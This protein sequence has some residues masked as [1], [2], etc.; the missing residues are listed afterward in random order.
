[1]IDALRGVFDRARKTVWARRADVIGAAIPV[2]AVVLAF[3][4]VLFGGR[5][6]STAS[7]S[8]GTNGFAPFPGQRTVD[9]PRLYQL[10]TGASAWAF[11][12]WAVV[13]NR[14]IRDGEIPLW[15]PYQGAGAPLAANM[16]SAPFDPLFALVDL[17]P[18]T[19]TWDA[20]FILSFA[21]AAVAT[22][23]LARLVRM[24]YVA[25]VTASVTYSL[26]GYFF[27]YSNNHF[28]VVYVY[29]PILCLCAEWVVRSGRLLATFA[30]AA[31]VAACF[32]VGMPEAQ[33]F[34]LGAACA[35]G[36]WRAFVGGDPDRSGRRALLVLGGFACGAAMAA[37]LLLPFREY[38]Q[39][40]YNVHNSTD[41]VG[42][43][44]SPWQYALGWVFPYLN[45]YPIRSTTTQ[46]LSGTVN[47]I[48]GGAMF[49]VL[50]GVASRRRAARFLVPFFAVVIVVLLAKVYG[51]PLLRW[52]G[53]LPVLN[54][55]NFPRYCLPVVGFG[56]AMLAGLGVDAIRHRRING[57]VLAALA[58]LV[59]AL[60]IGALIR[61][62][63]V[64]RQ[65]PLSQTFHQVGV[66]VGAA[67]VIA[68]AI[69]L[70]R[71]RQAAFVAAGVVIIE[72]LVL[73]P[74]ANGYA[75]RAEP[76]TP[77]AWTLTLRDHLRT[78]PTDRVYGLDALLFP[79]DAGAL[80]MYDIRVLDA[81]YVSRYWRYIHTFIE[82][83]ASSRFV[84]GPYGITEETTPANYENNSMF[85]LLGVRYLVARS[86]LTGSTS[87]TAGTPQWQFLS[88]QDGVQI[89]R[90]Q[91]AAPR[92]F[93]ATSVSAV[94]ST[95]AAVDWFAARSQRFSDGALDVR[96]IDPARS[97]VI[98]AQANAVPASVGTAASCAGQATASITRYESDRVEVAV[99][100]AC[101]GLLV[102]SDTYY[103]GWSARVNGHRAPIHA[104]DIAFRGVFVDTG[105]STVVFSYQPSSFRFGL[106]LSVAAFLVLPLS[107]FVAWS[108]RRGRANRLNAPTE[109]R[110]R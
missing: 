56:L 57:V 18:S 39:V 80:N 24:G 86:P 90:N 19:R 77:P 75:L 46:F 65:I 97:A 37:P 4:P 3:S 35:F 101:P 85:D 16:Q 71:R 95:D 105:R 110:W 62:K 92:A 40:S 47:W 87:P 59:G 13:T 53:D 1:V 27:L 64:L 93:V 81:L 38:E 8:V 48:G 100:S 45:G 17:D 61:Y 20:C 70:L 41:N 78:A 28:V 91:N 29:L 94:R 22:Y 63:D 66:A 52:I 23:L 12:P 36:L 88:S 32:A 83:Q 11:E 51:L 15:N 25:A 6:L 7:Y 2:V 76:F 34:V 99:D 69:L 58:V 74:A 54:R 42:A 82:P 107:A 50:V 9:E 60:G 68:L 79:N 26:S 104:T 106:V 73:A 89:F 5:T 30:L 109:S 108:V 103:P 21:L 72:L 49:L 10:D 84:G 96:G 44:E 31:A 43:I 98:E 33:L 67:T 14:I 102:L 55:S